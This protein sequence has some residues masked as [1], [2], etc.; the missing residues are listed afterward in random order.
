MPKSL[1][2]WFRL[3]CFLL[4]GAAA[5]AQFENGAVLGTVTD[6][7]GG[8]VPGCP[9]RLE[10]IQK[11]VSLTAVTGGQ[12]A[13]EF[14]NVLV[15]TYRLSANCTGFKVS[16]TSP[17]DVAVSA[18]QRVDL[19]VQVGNTAET[20][21]VEG[22]VS[23]IESESSDRGQVVHRDEVSAVPLN[24][25]AYADLA[26]LVPGVRKSANAASREGSFNANGLR[27]G[28]NNFV[29]DGVDNNSYATSSGAGTSRSST[30][31]ARDGCWTSA[32]S[33]I[34]AW[35]CSSTAI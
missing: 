24:G 35:A 2:L 11:A 16:V 23:P 26:L 32:M 27:S 12:G 31:W 3:V 21:S 22:A 28:L 4:P 9:V 13:Y 18:R 33:A 15:G 20:I 8:V 14:P 30:P 17:F 25:R 19:R 10:N 7:T 29:M 6:A 1:S 5:L 34:M